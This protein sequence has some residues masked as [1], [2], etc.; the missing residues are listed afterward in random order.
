MRSCEICAWKLPF[1][2][3]AG[4]EGL[5][6]CPTNVVMFVSSNDGIVVPLVCKFPWSK[7]QEAEN[8]FLTVIQCPCRN[9]A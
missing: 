8:V 7:Y 2:T 1:C 6:F 3:T 9:A 5:L 4:K